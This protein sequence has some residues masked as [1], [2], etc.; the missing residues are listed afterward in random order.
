MR[1]LVQ[2]ISS[3]H[4]VYLIALGGTSTPASQVRLMVFIF[5]LLARSR[6]TFYHDNL[7]YPFNLP[8]TIHGCI[9]AIKREIGPR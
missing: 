6:A 8:R 3:E 9:E 4:A 1:H 2:P 5:L 7:H